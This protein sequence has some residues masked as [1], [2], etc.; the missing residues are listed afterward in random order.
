MYYEQ[1][2]SGTLNLLN[3]MDALNA[4]NCVFLFGNGLWRGCCGSIL[5]NK[6]GRPDNPYG[7]TKPFIEKIIRDWSVA[8]IGRSAL[9]YGISIRLVRMPLG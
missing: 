6:P 2:V 7:R 1:N 8:G 9:C 3:Q 4:G 5:R